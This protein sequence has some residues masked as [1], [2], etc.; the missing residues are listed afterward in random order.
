MRICLPWCGSTAGIGE[1]AWDSDLCIGA[2]VT[3]VAGAPL[4]GCCNTD[5]TCLALKFT[6]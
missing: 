5:G 1:D 3:K 2:C 4:R 6:V